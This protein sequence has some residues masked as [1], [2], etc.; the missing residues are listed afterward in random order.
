MTG[1]ATCTGRLFLGRECRVDRPSNCLICSKGLVLS[2]FGQARLYCSDSCNKK[3]QYKRHTEKLISRVLVWR[4]Q[5]GYGDKRYA[6]MIAWR[7]ALK[8]VPCQDCEGWFDP[9]CMD[10]DHRPGEHKVMSIADMF[11]RAGKMPKCVILEE[12]AKCDIVCANC[13]RL[14]TKRRRLDERQ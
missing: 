14:R 3:A 10:F 7:D 5:S 12:V 2:K 4:K 8:S 11:A 6:R 1:T 13:H 9:I